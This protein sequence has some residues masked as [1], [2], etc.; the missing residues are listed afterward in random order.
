M[1]NVK[2]S[3]ELKAQTLINNFSKRNITGYYCENKE[4]ALNKALELLEK[5]SSI[6]WGGSL[7]LDQIGLKN[8][9]R[10][11]DFEL[12]DREKAKDAK[13][14]NE[15]MRKGLLSDYFLTSSNAI[16]MNGELINID[17]NGNRVAAMIY[18]PKNVII[19]A[20]MNKI[21]SSMDVALEKIR[22][23]ACQPN[24]I[25]LN[26]KTPCSTTGMCKDCLSND[27]ICGHIVVTRFSRIP[28]RIKV[29]LVGENLGY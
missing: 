2:K 15:I 22:H 21:V 4:D 26:L 29:I 3:Y 12:I 27:C 5:D 16:T 10:E 7:T 19:I 6:S 18:G 1:D 9:L 11:M 24:A 20:G 23:D 14:K 17:G 8:K 25:R 13:E 28:N